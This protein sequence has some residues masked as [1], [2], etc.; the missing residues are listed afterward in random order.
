MQRALEMSMREAHGGQAREP[1]SAGGDM[2]EDEDL[3]RALAMSI[4]QSGSGG[5]DG[6]AATGFSDPA[7]VHQMLAGSDLSD[8][9][10]QA[11]LAQLQQAGEHKHEGEGKGED[12][13]DKSR[14]RNRRDS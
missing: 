11:A 3:A 8:P 4:E 2:D 7:F 9:I 10:V 5:G 6:Q 13:D 12:E 14:K 1:A